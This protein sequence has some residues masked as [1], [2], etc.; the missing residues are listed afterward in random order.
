MAAI[1]ANIR[2]APEDPSLPKPWRGL[3]DGKTGYIYFWNPETNVTQYQKPGTIQVKPDS[4]DKCVT[5]ATCSSVQAQHSSQVPNQELTTID[6][7]DRN[8]RGSDGCGGRSDQNHKS[9]T[10][11]MFREGTAVEVSFQ[12]ENFNVWHVGTV[13]KAT[14]NDKCLVK[15]QCPG[16]DNEHKIQEFAYSP[17]I[18]P[19][20][21][22]LEDNDYL[23][24]EKVEAY[25]ECCWWSGKIR[26][27]LEDRRYIVG[28]E[29]AK[30]E[31][32]FEH[33]NLRP[34]MVWTDG[35]WIN[36]KY[37]K[38]PG[39]LT[40][41]SENS[42]KQQKWAE[43]HQDQNGFVSAE[44]RDNG[45]VH[46][47]EIVDKECLTKEVDVPDKEAKGARSARNCD[48]FAKKDEKKQSSEQ[49]IHTVNCIKGSTEGD[50]SS[51]R[52]RGRPKA[53][54][55]KKQIG[56]I[57]TGAKMNMQDSSIGDEAKLSAEDCVISTAVD[58]IP[59]NGDLCGSTKKNL[60]VITS[61]RKL[62]SRGRRPNRMVSR[63][64]NIPLLDDQA[65]ETDPSKI[66]NRPDN[67]GSN[68]Q[69]EMSRTVDSDSR[70]EECNKSDNVKDDNV[71]IDEVGDINDD[72][73]LSTWLNELPP[74]G[75]ESSRSLPVQDQCANAEGLHDG[76]RTPLQRKDGPGID[77]MENDSLPFVKCSPLWK[78]IDS[79]ELYKTQK[80][81]F[82][83]LVKS[84]EEI[85]E[86]LAIGVLV[87]FSN[88][89]ENTSK[90]Q[91]SSDIA[92][93]ERSL[94]TLPEFES[95]G[96]D[97]KKVRSCLT[98][99]LS[100]KKQAEEL[101]KEYEDIRNEL[102][103][104][105]YEGELDEEINQLYQKFREI[106]KKLVEAKLKKETREKT[107]S[108]L[109]SRRDVVAKTVQSLEAEFI[110][111]A[112]SLYGK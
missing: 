17:N 81:H 62:R 84:R 91:F 104:S 38:R 105:E 71:M 29:H 7:N 31:M 63:T 1:T 99:L 74:V 9:V 37:D 102:S 69:G 34:C 4:S 67:S 19:S 59:N 72:Q 107:L 2:Y 54:P 77:S 78:N 3:I 100:K 24:L 55:K 97:V 35:K 15:Y 33:A 14:V 86:G 27:L 103:N 23:L 89:V 75:S 40:R 87:N 92:I 110:N 90:L 45:G 6:G 85:R 58:E 12:K 13:M 18:R 80:P 79:M 64:A 49:E 95:H 50:N 108:A 43:E 16:G 48:L 22:S 20:P 106:E 47:E 82:S 39:V 88:L 46:V 93:I 52:K 73:P 109:Q 44:K 10:G 57:I 51:K 53:L 26:R 32:T 42:D 56:E 60:A 36:E 111:V 28:I 112:G 98:Q 70:Y 94:E 101:Q 96:F 5:V 68:G 25:F 83:P 11:W 21:P 30:K 8:G 61:N 76:F 41:Q 66:V 65:G